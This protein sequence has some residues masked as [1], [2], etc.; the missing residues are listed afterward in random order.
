M[1]RFV[2]RMVFR[3]ITLVIL[4]GTAFVLYNLYESGQLPV[5]KRL[6]ED[7]A[8]TA[9]VR[10]GFAIH[11]DLADRPIDV[12]TTGNVVT[13]SGRVAS[14]EEKA[15]A[16]AIAAT[17]EGVDEIANHLEI[18]PGLE[19]T[20]GETRKSFGER[21]DDAA[22]LAKI[23]TALHLDREVR[24]LDVDIRVSSGQVILRGEIP[25]E[26]LMERIRTR[27]ASVRGVERLEDELELKE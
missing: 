15:E 25:S 11:R 6:I 5:L 23:R 26:A 10:A 4:A 16:E 2:F 17:I 27:V 20:D 13:L 24:K 22:L 1:F 19:D 14:E 3:A 9:S 18:E 8:V 21:L 12:S 7:T